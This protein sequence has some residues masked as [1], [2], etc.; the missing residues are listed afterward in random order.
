MKIYKAIISFIFC[1]I[2]LY[3][4]FL[5]SGQAGIPGNLPSY[6]NKLSFDASIG[7]LEGRSQEFVFDAN[8]G[9]KISQLN[10]QIEAAS[11]IKGSVHYDF[12]PIL[13]ASISGWNTIDK[14]NGVMDD[15]DWL[16]TAQSSP[17]DWSH[18]ED[19]PLKYA[20]E[21]DLNLIGWIFQK[22]NYQLGIMGGYHRSSLSFSSY[23]GW[24]QYENAE[25]IGV[26]PD[27]EIGIGYQQKFS[28]GYFGLVG[29]Y[30]VNAVDFGIS[31]KYGPK[32]KASDVDQHYQR[33]LIF[34][35]VGQG[36]EYYALAVSSGYKVTPRVRLFAEGVYNKYNN[37]KAD[38][39]IF[40]RNSSQVFNIANAAGLNYTNYQLALGI[41]YHL[42]PLS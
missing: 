10:W 40:D 21:I 17:T 20:N 36:G 24:F 4:P 37:Q 26:V 35:G 9:R 2:F 14:G 11:I 38:T 16:Y 42:S 33:S 18:H 22:P 6:S 19:T 15:F 41:Q 29:S 3:S 8:S 31:F 1:T 39:T 25:N 34:K 7:Y 32:V 27:N 5:F 28:L 12:S 13:T 30:F 23:G